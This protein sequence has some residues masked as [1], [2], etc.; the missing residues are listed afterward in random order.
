MYDSARTLLEDIK[1]IPSCRDFAIGELQYL[2][3]ITRQSK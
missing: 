3:H 1:N 2:D